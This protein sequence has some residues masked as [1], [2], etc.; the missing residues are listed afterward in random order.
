M[1]PNTSATAAGTS[2]SVDRSYF[3]PVLAS[4]RGRQEVVIGLVRRTISDLARYR[5]IDQRAG[6]VE[7]GRVMKNV[8]GY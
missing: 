5:D 2:Q 7:L 4:V 8:C 1:P 3:K 6:L